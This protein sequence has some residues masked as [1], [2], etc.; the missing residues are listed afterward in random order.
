[1]QI[2]VQ[3]IRGLTAFHIKQGVTV[4]RITLGPIDT[5][6]LHCKNLLPYIK[7]D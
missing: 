6:Q 1:M 3:V 4:C 2:L 5:S 7:Q